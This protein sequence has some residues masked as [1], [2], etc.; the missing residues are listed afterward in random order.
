MSIIADDHIR[1]ERGPRLQ[2]IVTAAVRYGWEDAAEYYQ[3][4]GPGL[5]RDLAWFLDDL[6]GGARGPFAPLLL[7]IADAAAKHYDITE[8][9]R[10]SIDEDG[11]P[12]WWR[13][14]D[15]QEQV[16]HALAYA[17]ACMHDPITAD[18]WEANR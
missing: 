4:E 14:K 17:L 6:L 2:Q 10:V 15:T 3:L 11:F 16:V 18:E 9:R 7:A 12:D 13:L 5:Q 1:F 8:D